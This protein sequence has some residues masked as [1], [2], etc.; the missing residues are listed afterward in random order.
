MM[1]ICQHFKDNNGD[2]IYENLIIDG[3]IVY[4]PEYEV[5]R[6]IYDDITSNVYKMAFIGCTYNCS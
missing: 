6:D 1:T 4:E 5:L 3:N 2:Y